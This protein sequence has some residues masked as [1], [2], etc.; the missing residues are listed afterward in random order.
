MLDVNLKFTAPAELPDHQSLQDVI[1]NLFL[2][3]ADC[4]LPILKKLLQVV[5]LQA[6][7]EQLRDSE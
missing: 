1:I 5:A 4:Q 3:A 6:Y 2:L 7:L